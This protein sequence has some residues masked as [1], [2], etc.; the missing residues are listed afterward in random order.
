MRLLFLKVHICHAK[1]ASTVSFDLITRVSLPLQL[2]KAGW[3]KDEVDL[4]ELNEAF[5]AQSIAVIKEL[6]LDLDKVSLQTLD[7]CDSLVIGRRLQVRL[8]SGCLMDFSVS[9]HLLTSFPG[10]REWWCD[11]S[12]PPDRSFRDAHS[13]DA[14][15]RAGEN[16][17]AQGSRGAVRGRGNGNRHVRRTA[18]M[19]RHSR[20][21][22]P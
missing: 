7:R 16:G 8:Q 1:Y 17:L 20:V 15:V 4:F 12:W 21:L 3:T 10:E 6:G 19:R 9:R 11:C 13:G 22:R 18:V 2:R 14:A 5:A